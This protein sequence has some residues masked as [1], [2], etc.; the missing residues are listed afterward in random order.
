MLT[1]SKI[2]LHTITPTRRLDDPCFGYAFT[3]L[4][5]V[6]SQHTYMSSIRMLVQQSA[7]RAICVYYAVSFLSVDGMMVGKWKECVRS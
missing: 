4:H 2:L 7:H 1:G 5:G 6:K 3:S